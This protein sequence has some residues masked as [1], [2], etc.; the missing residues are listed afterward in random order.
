MTP[1][2]LVELASRAVTELNTIYPMLPTSWPAWDEMRMVLGPPFERARGRIGPP[3]RVE[4]GIPKRSLL[5]IYFKLTAI[6]GM[7]D[8]IF[9]E[10]LVN[11]DVLPFER[12]FIVAHEWGHLAGRANE[13]EASFLGWLTCMD[14][15]PWA[16]YSAWI[17]LLRRH[18]GRP[19]RT[20]AA[21][22]G[23]ETG[24]GPTWRSS[25]TQGSDRPD[26]A[27][28]SPGARAGSLTTVS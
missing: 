27:C 20:D 10:V 16:R 22:H 8:P 13:S 4:P 17:S 14:G 21:G 23:R 9:L 25:G 3:W 24:C 6:E 11:Q 2:A 1:D 5:N 26:K 12:P 18:H 28:P 15:P 7:V 19:A